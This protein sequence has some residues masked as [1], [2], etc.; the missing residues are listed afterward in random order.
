MDK[1]KVTDSICHRWLAGFTVANPVPLAK[2]FSRWLLEVSFSNQITSLSCL[3]YFTGNPWLSGYN[4][5]SWLSTKSAKHKALKIWSPPLPHGICPLSPADPTVP[6]TPAHS[7][8]YDAVTNPH[9]LVLITVSPGSSSVPAQSGELTAI[10][11][12][13]S[14]DITLLTKAHIVKAM[15]FPVVMYGCET[16]TIKKAEC[17]KTDVLELWCQ[18]RLLR[19]PW[20]ARRSNQST[21]KEISPEYSLEGLM[22]KLKLQHFGHLMSRANSLEKTLMLGKIEGK[23][24]ES[25]KG[26]DG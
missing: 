12:W 8:I 24:E 13:K 9:I 11:L 6:P 7:G 5:N 4:S 2:A 18:K 17:W 22:L 26:W 23:G 20:T 25:G 14:R 19:V 16:W 10:C 15:V 21:L 3:K 1:E